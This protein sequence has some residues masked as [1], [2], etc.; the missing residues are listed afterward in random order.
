M[1]FFSA[2]SPL[3]VVKHLVLI[4][5]AGLLL[6]LG[7]FYVYL[8]MTTHHGE[9]ITVP[10]VTGMNVAD[11]EDYLEERNLAYFVDDSSYS[12]SIRPFT[13]LVQDPAPGEKVK[14]GRKIYLQVSMKNPP[15]IKMP[16]LTD[17][18]SKN[19]MLILKSYDLVV[20]Q[21]QLVPDLAQN[22]VLKQLVNGKEIAPGAPI[23]KG[24]KVDLVVGDGQ[25]NQTF[26][27]PYLINMPEDEAVTLLVG[28]GLQK[29]E[30]FQVPAESGQVP[31]TVVRQRPIAS[32]DATI[33]MGQLV[34]I[35]VA[36]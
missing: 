8:P 17:G 18:S 27:V 11:L 6:I 21:I 26:A 29:G 4:A 35:W 31:G 24:T 3:D 12:P 30:V 23:A 33:R 16:K 20:G 1:S 7:F 9:T 19:A 13:V 34:D 28:Q 22:A 5:I 15:V 2:N 36:Q 14:E 32:P 25:G 10:K